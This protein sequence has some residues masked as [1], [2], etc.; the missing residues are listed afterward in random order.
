MSYALPEFSIGRFSVDVGLTRLATF[1]VEDG[2]GG[3]VDI[4]G[5]YDPVAD[6]FVSTGALPKLRGLV[7]LN[8]EL[9]A[10]S[11]SSQYS[12]MSSFQDLSVSGEPIDRDIPFYATA[13]FQVSYALGEGGNEAKWLPMR[14]MRVSL[15]VENAFDREVPFIVFRNNYNS[16]ENDLRGRFVYARLT[17]DF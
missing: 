17:T 14:A 15:G 2:N 4:A 3:L 9:G 13:D 12:F 10:W 16:F 11:A 8:W 6:T 7:G 5:G 1:E